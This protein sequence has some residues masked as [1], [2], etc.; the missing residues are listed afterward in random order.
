V[1]RALLIAGVIAL[2]FAGCGTDT[3]DSSKAEEGIESASLSGAKIES[4]SCPDD[5]E[6]QEGETFTC[7]VKL[8]GGGTAAVTVRQTSSR[9]TF[10]YAFKSGSVVLP[11]SRV[12]EA[13]EEN[14]ADSG[15]EGATVNCPKEV[16]VKTGVTTTCPVATANGG[17]GTVEFEFS[18]TSGEVD[19]SSV[20]EQ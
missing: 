6:K 20:Q 5:V 14:L 3:I 9:N 11:G 17:Q 13:L 15:V 2:F 16:P 8:E 18:T 12:D 19:P 1:N 7:D 10:S 4:A